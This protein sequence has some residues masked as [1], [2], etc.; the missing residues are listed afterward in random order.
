MK[1]RL[2]LA[3]LL[4]SVFTSTGTKLCAAE[5]KGAPS[6]LL[7]RLLDPCL[8]A[9]LAPLEENPKMPR[10]EVEKLRSSFAG[11]QIKAK[12]RAQQQ[13]YQNAMAVC[14][15]LTTAMDDR[16]KARS[17]ALASAKVTSVTNGSGIAKNALSNGR[18]A[19]RTAEAIRKKQQDERKYADDL[20]HGQSSFVETGAYK[21]WTEKATN[22]RQSVMALYTRQVQL[23]ALDE[24]NNP[25]PTSAEQPKTKPPVPEPAVAPVPAPETAVG[26]LFNNPNFENGTDGWTLTLWEKRGAIGIDPNES[27][28]GKPSL[29]IDNPDSEH[30]LVNQKVT[31]KP[32]TRYLL[33][34]YIK[35]K[36]V[37]PPKPGQKEGAELMVTG[38][39]RRTVP[40]SKTNSWTRVTYNLT[41]GDTETEM[42]VGM[43]LGHYGARLKGT[44]WFSELSL[45]EV[46]SS[47]KK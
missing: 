10:V 39:W 5:D 42:V 8:D 25:T 29:R 40:M 17:D 43:S 22:L 30:S 27:H 31:V 21:A 35:T 44:A 3:A 41:T 19:G 4:L 37:E 32:H 1:T 47:G 7:E 18:D 13:I 9:I 46:G 24:R 34:G 36:N 2:L 38:G 14:T 11:G 12:T 15:A 20:A 33:A 45:T 26:N 16:A 6:A 23:E 28:N